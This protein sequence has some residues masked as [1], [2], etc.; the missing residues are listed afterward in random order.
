MRLF[1][2]RLA[3]M[4]CGRILFYDSFKGLIDITF[5]WVIYLQFW[6]VYYFFRKKEFYNLFL[7][8]WVF[9][10]LAFMMK[11][12][13]ALV[14][15]GITLLVWFLL[16]R[17]LRK[18]SACLICGFSGFSAYCRI[19][20]FVYNRYNSIGQLFRSPCHRVDQTHFS[21]ESFLDSSLKHLFTFPVEFL[22]HF[23]PWTLFV[24]VF[25]KKGS[26]RF[27]WKNEAV[28]FMILLLLQRI[29]WFTGYLRPFMPATF[30][31]SFRFFS[32]VHF[33]FCSDLC[34]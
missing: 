3:L 2:L 32:E 33:T 34:R 22:F 16:N 18:F 13:P 12:L 15:Q 6:S 17:S 27:A 19:L 4:T 7:L 23:L 5:S 28:R 1:W 31:C 25:L 11:G 8:S 21:G 24:L 20:F 26:G 10:T 9:T 29:L 14:F 30:S